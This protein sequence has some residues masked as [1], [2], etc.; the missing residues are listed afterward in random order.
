MPDEPIAKFLRR[1]AWLLRRAV[2]ILSIS[3]AL[4]GTLTPVGVI[5][6]VVAVALV[7]L[8]AVLREAIAQRAAG[9]PSLPVPRRVAIRVLLILA[10]LAVALVLIYLYIGQSD[11]MRPAFAP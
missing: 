4:R 11:D 3:A 6:A 10:A 2:G 9:G 8:L 7:V 1:T 5:L